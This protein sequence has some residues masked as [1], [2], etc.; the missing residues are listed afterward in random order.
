MRFWQCHKDRH[1]RNNTITKDAED[2]LARTYLK[3]CALTTT[4]IKER[5]VR[6]GFKKQ[7]FQNIVNVFTQ[8]HALLNHSKTIILEFLLQQLM[9][10]F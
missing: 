6:L 4:E 2:A 8:L 5:H 9:H 10:E 1:S 7:H 3:L